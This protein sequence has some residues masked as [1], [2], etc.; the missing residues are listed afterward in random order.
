MAHTH[1]CEFSAAP[2]SKCRCS[3]NG[4]QHGKGSEQHAADLQARADYHEQQ[5]RQIAQE[6]G[7]ERHARLVR[8]QAVAVRN[9]AERIDSDRYLYEQALSRGERPAPE[10]GDNGEAQDE[11]V[12][13]AHATLGSFRGVT[14]F[15]H[16]D[17]QT[18]EVT[19]ETFDGDGRSDNIVTVGRDGT[20]SPYPGR[21]AEGQASNL[22]H[23]A[24]TL[25]DGPLQDQ[26][27]NELHYLSRAEGRRAHAFERGYEDVESGPLF[28]KAREAHD[29]GV[30]TEREVAALR[31]DADRL[32]R[33]VAAAKREENAPAS[34]PAR[35]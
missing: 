13:D 34:P 4:Q 31:K 9:A 7:D 17:R 12:N 21:C 35:T 24:R 15:A 30:R 11:A 32:D 33:S 22:R 1:K 27:L 18:G 28:A 14:T 26:R 16:R 20:V 23:Q 2:A 29:A 6:D 5:A 19:V 8:S 3:C 10:L 25:Q